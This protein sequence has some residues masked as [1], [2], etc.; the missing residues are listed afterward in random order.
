MKRFSTKTIG[1]LLI[2]VGLTLAFMVSPAQ[3][4]PA[5]TVTLVNPVPT[6]TANSASPAFSARV[7]NDPT[8]AGYSF[9][10]I[11]ITKSDLTQRWT[12][13]STAFPNCPSTSASKTSTLSNCGVSLT[14]NAGTGGSIEVYVSGNQIFLSFFGSTLTD[15]TFSFAPGTWSSMRSDGSYNFNV[16]NAST[17]YSTTITVAAA[18]QTYTVTFDGN[19]STGGSTAAQTESSNTT[20]ALTSNGFTRSGYTFAGWNTTANGS[21]T[22]YADGDSY[23]FTSSTTLFAQWTA[24][25]NGGSGGG[26]SGSSST[27]TGLANTGFASIPYLVLGGSLTVLGFVMTFLNRPR[28]VR[29]N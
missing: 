28:R 25:S 17:T 6:F 14:Q 2:A 3:A 12:F 19:S 26:S 5:I 10:A 7:V 15:V 8:A 20:T 9:L 27:D 24:N 29:R 22:A 4:S 18:P 11:D 13:N 23:A 16:T 21:G 1:T